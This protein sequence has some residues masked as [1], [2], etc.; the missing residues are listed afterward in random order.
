MKQVIWHDAHK[1]LPPQGFEIYL[2]TNIPIGTKCMSPICNLG[3]PKVVNI[4]GKLQFDNLIYDIGH[5]KEY[6]IYWAYFNQKNEIMIKEHEK[7]ME[8]EIN[9]PT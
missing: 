9:L 1:E 6:K 3:K 5:Y 4:L 8:E 2:H 7:K